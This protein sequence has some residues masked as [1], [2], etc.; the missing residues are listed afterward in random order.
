MKLNF[1]KKKKMTVKEFTKKLKGLKKELQD[2]EIVIQALNGLFFPPEIKFELEE[3][4]KTD[5][6][7]NNV[8]RVILRW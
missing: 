7:K 3:P 8:K 2:K 1:R 4:E 5:L 6:S